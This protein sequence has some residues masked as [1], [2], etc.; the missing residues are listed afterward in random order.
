MHIRDMHRLLSYKGESTIS[1][2]VS[3]LEGSDT[4]AC[5]VGYR[6]KP[7]DATKALANANPTEVRSPTS[8]IA[9]GR[10]QLI[11]L[12]EQNLKSPEELE[13]EDR[14]AKSAVS[15]LTRLVCTVR[16]KM[17][18]GTCGDDRNCKSSFEEGDRKIWRSLKS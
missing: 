12:A 10:M 17:L 1:Y 3:V 16:H 7:F 18:N 5:C 13:E 4:K 11:S 2:S 15:K 6:F 9:L 14:A 8:Y